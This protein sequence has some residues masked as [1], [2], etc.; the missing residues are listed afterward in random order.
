MMAAAI[1]YNGASPTLAQEYQRI[2][3]QIE[4]IEA[5]VSAPQYQSHQVLFA[6]R[7]L[8]D[9]A[10]EHFA[11]EEE[12]GTDAAFPA[13]FLHRLDHEYLLKSLRDYIAALVDTTEWPPANLRD[14]LRSWLGFHCRRYDEAYLRFAEQRRASGL[15]V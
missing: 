1:L 4:I 6:L 5:M 7:E 3:A 2:A 14:N 15:I 9:L 11:H 13:S 8:L 10:Q 12:S